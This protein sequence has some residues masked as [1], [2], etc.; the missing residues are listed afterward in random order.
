M[1]L[2]ICPTGVT[3]P[4][5]HKHLEVIENLLEVQY[6]SPHPSLCSV[7]RWGPLQSVAFLL[8]LSGVISPGPVGSQEHK[9]TT[10]TFVRLEE[11]L[12]TTGV[13]EVFWAQ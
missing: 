5:K 2:Q 3:K 6:G 8:P 12:R 7:R 9:P 11:G 13:T 10:G 1:L 4:G